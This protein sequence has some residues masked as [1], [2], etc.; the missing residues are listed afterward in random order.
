[1]N[2]LWQQPEVIVS[3][4][5]AVVGTIIWLVRLEGRQSYESKAS[6]TE[7]A[8]VREALAIVHR[9]IDETKEKHEEMESRILQEMS[10][11]KVSLAEIS[12]YLKK[13]GEK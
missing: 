5:S 6:Q 3:F 7:I 9:R 11:I 4:L 1:M 2:S 8:S 10:A 13:H 12:G